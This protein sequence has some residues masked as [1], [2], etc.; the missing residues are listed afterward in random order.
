MPAR[1]SA[2]SSLKDPDMRRLRAL[3]M[4][5][6]RIRGR[7]NREVAKEYNVSEDTVARTLTWAKKAQLVVAAEDRIIRELLPAA[8]E[9]IRQVLTGDD[10]KVKAKTAL[11]IFKGTLPSFAKGKTTHAGPTDSSGDLASYINS[12]RDDKLVD[13][14][15]LSSGRSLP[16]GSP[17][18]LITSGSAESRPEGLSVPAEGHESAPDEERNPADSE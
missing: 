12:L 2:C 3:G 17:Q 6:M 8:T 11:E 15:V 5:D 13:G 10:L 18:R 1:K 7:T 4:I 16:E 14:E 9:A